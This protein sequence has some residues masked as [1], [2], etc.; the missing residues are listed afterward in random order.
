M[1]NEAHPMEDG[2]YGFTDG[3]R[4]DGVLQLVVSL[5]EQRASCAETFGAE[6]QFH[7][8]EGRP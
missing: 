1:S 3:I 5:C 7:F 6:R 8:A 4:R 2:A